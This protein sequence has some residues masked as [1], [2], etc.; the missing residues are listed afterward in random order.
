MTDLL[1][2]VFEPVAFEIRLLQGRLERSE[3]HYKS[4]GRVWADY[5]NSS[6]HLLEH[7]AEDDGTTAVRL[8]RVRPLPVEL[9]LDFGE[10]L[11]ELRAALDNCLYAV[12]VLVSGENPPPSAAR[13]EWPIRLTPAEWKSQA[14]RYRDL[15][16]EITEALERIQ[17]YQADCPDW[18][19][20]AILHELARVDRHRSMHGLGLYLREFLL[21][22][23][24]RV[25]QVLDTG[26]PRIIIDGSEIMRM[27]VRDGLELSPANFDLHVEFDVDVTDVRE[28]VGPSGRRNRPWGSL[29]GRLKALI[30]ATRE[31]TTGLLGLAEEYV[32]DRGGADPL[33]GTAAAGGT[34]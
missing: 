7:T 13:L 34:H 3:H 21:Q 9:S 31:Y 32:R 2:P 5:L 33:S 17:P 19:C 10:L 1:N 6:P 12:A 25:V 24:E 26:S 18:N 23:D 15:P 16:A 27:R 22:A 11:Y 28:S 8:R 20:L 30:R 29:D 4:F 14:S